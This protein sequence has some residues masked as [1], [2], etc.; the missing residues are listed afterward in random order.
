[1]KFSAMEADRTVL[2]RFRYNEYFLSV[3]LFV[4]Y[5]HKLNYHLYVD[6]IISNKLE[7]FGMSI[8]SRG[9]KKYHQHEELQ[10]KHRKKSSGLVK[11]F[12]G[13]NSA[14][15]ILFFVLVSAEK[16]YF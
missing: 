4:K 2:S 3:Y 16:M 1:M 10:I 6:N 5:A 13:L 12:R 11:R 8:P 9:R 14:W 15:E 7:L